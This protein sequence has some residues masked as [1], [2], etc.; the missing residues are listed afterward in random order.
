MKSSILLFKREVYEETLHLT[1]H[2]MADTQVD[3][4]KKMDR[5]LEIALGKRPEA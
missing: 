4:A 5:T 3:G 1:S 2:V